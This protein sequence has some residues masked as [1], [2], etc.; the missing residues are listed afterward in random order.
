MWS[1]PL[2]NSNSETELKIVKSL[3]VCRKVDPDFRLNRGLVF[4]LSVP[5][6]LTKNCQHFTVA[7]R[8]SYLQLLC[9][10]FSQEKLLCGSK[11]SCGQTATS[12]QNYR[13]LP[14]GWISWVTLLQKF[15]K[16]YISK[17]ICFTTF[18]STGSTYFEVVDQV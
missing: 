12:W 9:W 7:S 16:F 1:F 2:V 10:T 14:K 15:S 11:N 13:G 3:I 6:H 5:H 4:W 18:F 8:L 17:E